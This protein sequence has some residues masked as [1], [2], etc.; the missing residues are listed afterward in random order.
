MFKSPSFENLPVLGIQPEQSSEY[1]LREAAHDH[2][3]CTAE[4]AIEVLKLANDPLAAE[5]LSDYFQIFRQAYI[6][7]KPHLK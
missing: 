3:L 5:A 2:Q 1:K 4:V 6:K 7:G